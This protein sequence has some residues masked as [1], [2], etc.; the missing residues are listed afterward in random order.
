MV[1]PWKTRFLTGEEFVIQCRVVSTMYKFLEKTMHR[2]LLPNILRSSTTVILGLASAMT[3]FALPLTIAMQ[4]G[5]Y[6][7]HSELRLHNGLTAP[8]ASIKCWR[9]WY[10]ETPSEPSKILDYMVLGALCIRP[11]F[12]EY[13]LLQGSVYHVIQ[14]LQCISSWR[15]QWMEH[16]PI[17]WDPRQR[18]FLDLHPSYLPWLCAL[19]FTIAMQRGRYGLQ[20]QRLDCPKW[21]NQML[22]EIKTH[23]LSLLRHWTTMVL[24]ALCIRPICQEYTVS[25]K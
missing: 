16:Y 19:P 13:M 15:R 20:L 1:Q 14:F 25:G 17:S 5:R 9:L 8:N 21:F 3:M 23:L 6:G 7:F 10:S 22:K 12:Q 24:D 18:W 4:R 2:A 11:I